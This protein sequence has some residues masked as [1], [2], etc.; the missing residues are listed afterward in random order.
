MNEKVKA[1]V[2]QAREQLSTDINDVIA[3]ARA[4]RG[5]RFADAAELLLSLLNL[6]TMAT[7]F[8]Q[9]ARAA[10]A[11]EIVVSTFDS[12]MRGQA[13]S[14]AQKAVKLAGLG[15]EE[16]KEAAELALSL[17]KRA[18]IA[19]EQLAARHGSTMFDD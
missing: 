9:G 10:G 2:V 11:P 12:S 14:A 7:T 19:A 1:S 5:D 17:A 15:H 6:T 13:E 8:A 3:S 4:V 16:G 18:V